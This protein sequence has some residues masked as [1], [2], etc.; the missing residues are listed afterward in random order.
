[1]SENFF[2]L[3]LALW[4]SMIL[5]T[6]RVTKHLLTALFQ[7]KSILGIEAPVFFFGI[8]LFCF[9]VSLVA[10]KSDNPLRIP[11]LVIFGIMGWIALVGIVHHEDKDKTPPS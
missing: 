3:I 5:G 9:F 7:K 4:I 1:M 8:F 10:A 11:I 2:A 6:A